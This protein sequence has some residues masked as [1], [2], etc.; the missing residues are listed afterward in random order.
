M[1][2]Q[3]HNKKYNNIPIQHNF[4]TKQFSKVRFGSLSVSSES[5]LRQQ[6]KAKTLT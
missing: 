6:I 1:S 5:V 2:I 4:L 3:E